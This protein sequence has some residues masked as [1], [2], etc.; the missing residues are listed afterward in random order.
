MKAAA[1]ART[2][3]YVCWCGQGKSPV[4]AFC[5]GCFEKLPAEIQ[6]GIRDGRSSAFR[7]AGEWLQENA[8]K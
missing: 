7:E 1:S 3:Q 8:S 5:W 6:A 4:L 2:G